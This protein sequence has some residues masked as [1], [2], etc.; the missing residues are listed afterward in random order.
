[1]KKLFL[2][3]LII[4]FYKICNADVGKETGLDIPR[5]IS[6]KFNDSNIRVG[7]SKNYPIILKFIQKNYPLMVVEEYEEWRKVK[8]FKNNT[9]WIHKSLISGI[10]TGIILPNDTYKK[11]DVFN[12]IFGN[13]IGSIG[14]G[15]IVTIKR[16]KTN[17]CLISLDNTQG[18]VSKKHLWGVYQKE[19]YNINFMQVIYDFYWHSIN[20]I[21]NLRNTN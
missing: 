13:K 12:S 15:N 21:Q 6:L 11:I 4:F 7:P 10:R 17:W 18:W 1:M 20:T 3:I 9:G 16:C 2:V 8:D 14:I 5:Y 19:N